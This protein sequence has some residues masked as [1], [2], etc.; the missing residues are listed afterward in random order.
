M[1][2]AFT[3]SQRRIF[4]G[5]FI[6]YAAAYLGRLNMSAALNGVIAG[7]SLTDAQGGM[8]QTVFALTYAAGQLVN[9]A[10]VDRI[11][12][13]RHI[14]TGLILSAVCNVIFGSSAAYGLMLTAW[15]LNGIAQSMLWTPIVKLM[16]VWF[17]GKA[18]G[19]ASFGLSMTMVVGHLSAWCISGYMATLFNWRL[20]FIIPAAVILALGAVAFALIKD[21][22]ATELEKEEIQDQS[23]TA[24][25]KDG[26]KAE[27]A[28]RAMPIPSMLLTTGLG[29]ILLCSIANGFVRDGIITWAPTIIGN[30]SGDAALGSS[31][32][33]SLIIPILNLVGVLLGRVIYSK[34]GD[35]ARWCVGMLTAGSAVLSLLVMAAVGTR[36]MLL[37]ALLLGCCCAATYGINPMLTTLIPMEYDKAG[38]VGLVAGLIDCFIYLGSSL[39]GIATG[40]LQDAMGW[41]AVFIAWCAVGVAGAV[42]AFLSM[43]G[44]KR[45]GE[46]AQKQ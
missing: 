3:K 13:R 19:R 6:A 33:F 46:W 25:S 39:A 38:R 29:L 15:C 17:F 26:K 45:I 24:E 4:L 31:V 42:L 1:A 11:S 8:F 28:G 5:C 7:M 9:G 12:A 21:A 36:S 34:K 32:L 41:N 10:M 43:S 18:R 2:K 35:S 44:R 40:A 16:S 37:S 20:S 27:P 23:A 22:P 30:L 14:V